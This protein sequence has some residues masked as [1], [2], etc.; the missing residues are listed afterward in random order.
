MQRAHRSVHTVSDQPW[1]LFPHVPVW[2]PRSCTISIRMCH[3]AIALLIA[4]LVTNQR[5]QD[6][7][8]TSRKCM[9]KSII[10]SPWLG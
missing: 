4:K 2:M 5:S 10:Q 8:S 6:D 3:Y 9:H 7:C 1:Q